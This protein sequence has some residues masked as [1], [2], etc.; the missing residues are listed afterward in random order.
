M[1]ANECK[2][3]MPV[4][5]SVDRRRP[6]PLDGL[7]LVMAIHGSPPR[8]VDQHGMLLNITKGREFSSF[9]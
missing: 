9:T 8:T 4:V 6:L 7:L 5:Y 2:R 1:R 3:D